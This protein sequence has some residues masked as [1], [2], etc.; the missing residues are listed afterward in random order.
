MRDDLADR[1]IPMNLP[2]ISHESK[3]YESYLD[4][5]R[6]QLYPEILGGLLDLCAKAL[7]RLPDVKLSSLPRMADFARVLQSLDEICV[8]EPVAS[9]FLTLP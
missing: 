4:K 7:E 1:I 8:T 6:E 3:Q 2:V 9:F 5:Q